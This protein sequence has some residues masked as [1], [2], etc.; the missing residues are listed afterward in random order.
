MFAVAI[1]LI[2]FVSPHSFDPTRVGP[3][4]PQSKI[5]TTEFAKGK[6]I[7]SVDCT[8]DPSQSYAVYLPSSYATE[9]KWPVLFAF[10]PIARGKVPVEHYKDAAEKFGWIVIGSNNS[11]NGPM[12]AS[13]TAWN[14]MVK[15]AQRRFRIDEQRVYVT[16]FSGGARLAIYLATQCQGCVAGVIA[17]GAGF[18]IGLN[19]A[20]RLPFPIFVTLGVDD[21]NFAEIT[22]LDRTL[23]KAGTAHLVEEFAGRHDWP[24]AEVAIDSIGWMELQAIRSGTRPPDQQF[25]QATWQAEWGRANSLVAA[26]KFYEA[27]QAHSAIIAAFSGLHDLA[28]AQ[29][30][31]A[32]LQASP[33][34]KSAVR[35]VQRQ[36]TRQ[37]EFEARVRSLIAASQR[38]SLRNDAEISSD[39]PR[40]EQNVAEGPT[41]ESQLKSLFADLRKQAAKQD[42]SSDRRV[43][44][45]VVNGAYI[46]FYEQGTGELSQKHFDAAAR[47]FALASDI[48]PE[49]AVAFFYLACAYA[50]KGDK[51][52][53]FRALK[54][55]V[56]HG[57]SDV[58]AIANNPLFDSIRD[59][60]QYRAIMQ[61]LQSKH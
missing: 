51:K 2:F 31:L 28:E 45:R 34:V 39:N 8:G 59:D 54:S 3:S 1:L 43:A 10:D 41:P 4:L 32:K 61:T 48:N 37:R 38:V 22:E 52:K 26:K 24:P 53:S 25:V 33:E 29:T 56:D 11:R 46:N 17:A 58:A 16:G 14:A 23:N 47:W 27:F 44:R 21:F 30:E 57:F 12:Q 36:I 5:Q 9:K 55:A 19:A 15:D 50:G 6:I 40:P 35:E 7:E 13:I 60:A 20:T 42:D 18:P 49:R